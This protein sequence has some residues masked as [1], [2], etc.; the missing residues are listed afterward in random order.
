MKWVNTIQIL[1][2]NFV[3]DTESLIKQNILDITK[4]VEML[5]QSWSARSLT[6]LGKITVINSLLINL[7]IG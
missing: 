6:P 2:V 3:S 1:G 7:C 5:V 4:K